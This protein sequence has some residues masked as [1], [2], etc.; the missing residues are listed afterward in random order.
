M[1]I[2]DS[3]QTCYT[4]FF[5]LNPSLVSLN[6]SPV[7]SFHFSMT[8]PSKTPP[9]SG[10][11]LSALP[12]TSFKCSLP[13]AGPVPLAHWHTACI[14]TELYPS[15]MLDFSFHDAVAQWFKRQNWSCHL[16][17]KGPVPMASHHRKK[18]KEH[19]MAGGNT[20]RGPAHPSLS[21]L[22]SQCSFSYCP[23]GVLVALLTQ[24][25]LAHASGSSNLQFFLSFNFQSSPGIIIIAYSSETFLDCP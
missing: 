15:Q 16:L 13:S 8:L 1:I 22:L 4:I 24:A 10:Q 7:I 6:G 3:I 17:P 23:P 9:K 20:R 18:N 21:L 5:F 12:H 2:L 11:T 25:M 19:F 14:T